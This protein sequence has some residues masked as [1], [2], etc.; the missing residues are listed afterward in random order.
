MEKLL[1]DRVKEFKEKEQMELNRIKEEYEIKIKTFKEKYKQLE[2]NEFN[3]LENEFNK[4][5][6]KLQ[7]DYNNRI[8]SFEARLKSERINLD[9]QV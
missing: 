5:K 1:A 6:E 8:T 9:K 3:Y 7:A 4:N 2:E